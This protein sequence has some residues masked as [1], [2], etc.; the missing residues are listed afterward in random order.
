MLLQSDT[1]DPISNQITLLNGQPQ[2]GTLLK[3]HWRYYSYD[4]TA[5][6]NITTEVIYTLTGAYGDPDLYLTWDD[7]LPTLN[8]FNLRRMSASTYAD[9]IHIDNPVGSRHIIGVYSFQTTSYTLLAQVTTTI[10]PTP[11][12]VIDGTPVVVNGTTPSWKYYVIENLDG[13]SINIKL[14]CKQQQ[15]AT[16]TTSHHL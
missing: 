9:V 3:N 6:V 14:T 5:T 8:H 16:T 2:R 12:Q 15:A 1:A 4:H 7:T 13:K 11:T 10:R